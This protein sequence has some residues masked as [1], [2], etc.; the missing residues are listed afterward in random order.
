MSVRVEKASE[1]DA[2][3]I[4]GIRIKAFAPLLEKYKDYDTNPANETIETVFQRI[5]HPNGGFYKIYCE[6]HLVG[7]ICAFWKGNET[8]YWVSPMFIA[9]DFQGKGIAQQ[10]LRLLEDMFPQAV[11][12]ELRTIKEEEWNCHLYE[13]M[14]YHLIGDDYILNENATLVHYIKSVG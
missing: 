13:K 3:A 5:H 4:L 2:E 8:Q 11:T 12:W 6:D 1:T 14:G 9:P 10:A 7:A